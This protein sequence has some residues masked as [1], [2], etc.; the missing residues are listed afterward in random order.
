MD[1]VSSATTMEERPHAPSMPTLLSPRGSGGR[2][3]GM[4]RG[5]QE[6]RRG[7]WGERGIEGGG[8]VK[9]GGEYDVWEPASEGGCVRAGPAGTRRRVGWTWVRKTICFWQKRYPNC[10]FFCSFHL[11]VITQPDG[12]VRCEEECGPE[13]DEKSFQ[14]SS[15][16]LLIVCHISTY[17]ILKQG[18]LLPLFFCP[19]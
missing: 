8:V 1:G 5:D 13:L 11:F 9:L 3:E 7:R 17:L 6:R 12:W 15:L 16:L 4:G 2:D 18:P 19:S 14:L 10:V